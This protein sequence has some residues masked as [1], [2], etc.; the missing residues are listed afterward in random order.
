MTFDDV[1]DQVITLLQREQRLSYR[2]L[3]RRFALDDEYLEDLKAELIQA[4]QLAR[5]EAGAVLVWTGA[6]AGLPSSPSAPSRLSPLPQ[7]APAPPSS[8]R[9]PTSPPLAG[10][11][12]QVTVLFADFSGFTALAETLDP[13][14][15]RQLM[16]ACFARLVPLVEVYGGTID[17]FI[18]DEIMALFGAPIAYD[19]DA[20]RAVRTALAMMDALATF[21]AEQGTALGLHCG[22]NTG[23]VIAGGIGTP[24]RQDYSVMGDAV[25]L[26]ARLEDASELGQILV[27]PETYRLTRTFF[28]YEPLAPMALKGKAD[29]VQVYQVLGLREVPEPPEIAA[30]EAL[31]PTLELLDLLLRQVPTMRMLVVVTCRPPFQPPWG[32]RSY[33]TP[34]MLSRLGQPQIEQ[35]VAHLTAGKALPPEVRRQIMVKTDGVPL[36]VE[37]C[38]KMVLESPLVREEDEQ[39]VLT[40]PLPPLAVPLTLQDILMARLD[41]WTPGKVVAQLGATV[42][43]EFAYGLLA[44][45]SPLDEPT[46]QHGLAQL[47]EAELLY[48][49]GHLPQAQYIF[50]HTLIQ[51]TAYQSLLRSTRQQYHQRIAH[52]LEAQ[53][54]AIVDQQPELLAYHYTEAGLT[55]QAVHYWHHAGQRTSERSAH[56]EAISHLTKGLALLQTLPE[57]RERVQLEVD[58]HIALGASLI[59]TKGHAAPEVRET[60]TYA[61]QLCQHLE[62]PQQLFSVLRGLVHHYIVR[63]EY[64]MAHALGEHLLTLAQQA[65]DAAMLVA[66]HATLGPTLYH[67]GAVASAHTHLAQGIALYDPQQYRAS[68]V[69][70]DDGE[71]AG[72]YCHSFSAWALWYL[73]YPDQGLAQSQEAM[74]LVQQRAHPYSLSFALSIAAM[75]HQFRREMRAA[76]E[77]AEAA[78]SLTKEQG[79]AYWMAV[80]SLIRGWALAYQ[81]QAQEGI[82][83]LTQ[84]L[85]AVRATG[86]AIAQPYWLA[87]LAEAHGSIGEPEAGLTVLTE[88]LTLVDTTGER[89]YEPE[90]YRF[91]GELLLQ[92]SSDYQAEAESC[93]HHAL[94]IARNQQAKSLELRA[95]TSLARVWQQQGKCEEARQV[96]SEV[97]GWF[98]EGF[99]TADLQEAKA[100]LEALG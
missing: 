62:E 36:F 86:A 41:H 100:L 46:L 8:S 9:T 51:E 1:L 79:F 63:A 20:E 22:L 93:F 54:P 89:W 17:K 37:E 49:R 73:G 81:G 59:A 16:N 67:L 21:N 74:T 7:E 35:M 6:P 27:G 48:Q 77:R 92:R 4:K 76:Q 96:L 56:M 61:R 98:T 75:F 71:D 66:A 19:N 83:Q 58:M 34:L 80:S 85:S 30:A 72:V 78:I 38:V 69:L 64:Q 52:A 18:G 55:E 13:E 47:V 2:A 68:A 53:F 57:T 87:L 33:L 3:K 5:D 95:A 14:D 60:Y 84:G 32:V 10:E 26:A 12:R 23:L 42:G 28:R 94:A 24:A 82:E 43:K 50:K 44:A 90:L 11:R 39:Y 40:G 65:Q 91:K 88:A 31:P 45:V 25:N 97:Y 29:P 70:Y 99:D 15:V